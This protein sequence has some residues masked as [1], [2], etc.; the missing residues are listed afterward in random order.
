MVKGY[1]LALIATM[2]SA[3]TPEA[4]VS[5][6][7]KRATH[8]SPG[9][10]RTPSTP[11]LYKF[12]LLTGINPAGDG[13]LQSGWFP[14]EGS[15][16]DVRNPWRSVSVSSARIDLV[17]LTH[18]DWNAGQCAVFVASFTNPINRT[19]WDIA[20][21]EP[22]LSFAGTWQGAVAISNGGAGASSLAF[23]GDR[24]VGGVVTPSAGGIHNVLSQ[25]NAAVETKDPTG[26][27][28]WFRIEF[29]NAYMKFGSGS[30]PNGVINPSGAEVACVNFTVEARKSALITP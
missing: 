11:T 18:G 25:N 14:G 9:A 20:G 17:N 30:S 7:A 27:N 19:N 29:R 15:S 23:D 4:V 12:R 8:E 5:A 1:S 28:D 13:E 3:C 26:N 21:T 24:V 16:L 6:A 10:A 2:L 22:L